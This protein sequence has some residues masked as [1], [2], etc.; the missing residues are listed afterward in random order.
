VT[1]VCVCVCVGGGGG[2]KG[3]DQGV[4]G[5]GGGGGG[6]RENGLVSMVF[7]PRPSGCHIQLSLA[8]VRVHVVVRSSHL[9]HF[10]SHICP[11]LWDGISTRQGQMCETQRERCKRSETV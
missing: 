5:V 3:G 2:G 11:Y 9:D 1:Q 10:F 8:F 7:H 6:G 4:V